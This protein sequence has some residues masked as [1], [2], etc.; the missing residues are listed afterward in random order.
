MFMS[1]ND[2]IGMAVSD[3]HRY[4]KAGKLVVHSQQFDDDEIPVS[5]LFRTQD[6]LPKLEKVALKHCSGKVLDV[7][8]CA[9]SH[10]LVLQSE[11]VD[12][13]ALELSEMCCDVMR[14]RGLKK[15]ISG[16]IY[17]FEH[18]GFDTILLLMNGT[19]LAGTIDN[20]PKLLRKLH[21]LLQ[22]GGQVLIDSSDLKYLYE[23]EDGSYLIDINAA[24]Y[25]E[26][27]FQMAYKT[28]RSEWFSWLYIDPDTFS[29]ISEQCGFSFEIMAEGEHYDYLA[30]LKKR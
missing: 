25:G 13:T 1:Q 29:M 22:A 3:Y 28:H 5:Y 6:E 30:R 9:G 19:G 11:N 10:A 8:A 27:D 17:A 16:D 2:P 21:A 24:Y 23:E 18:Y 7:G 26:V 20:M 15:V 14:L 12:V 4:G